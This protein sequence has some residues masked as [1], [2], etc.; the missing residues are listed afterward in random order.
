MKVKICYY[1][2]L[3]I[4]I[5]KFKTKRNPNEKTNPP[6]GIFKNNQMSNDF[7]QI[8]VIARSCLGGGG[9]REVQNRS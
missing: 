2:K 5:K 6:A 1:I 4:V 3:N 9:G 8:S 7:F